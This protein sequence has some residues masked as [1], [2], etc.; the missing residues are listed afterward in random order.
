MTQF[1]KI[2]VALDFSECSWLL[3]D[4][5]MDLAE[6]LDS[7]VVLTHIDELPNG[8]SA[9]T[10]VKTEEGDEVSAE[11]FMNSHSQK[12]MG[13]YKE[14]FD[15]RGL[16]TTT[17]VGRGPVAET[18]LE[19]AKEHDVNLIMMGTHGRRGMSRLLAG[20]VAEK[21]QRFADCPVWTS[22]TVHK[23]TCKARSCNWCDSHVTL[24]RRRLRGEADG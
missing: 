10:P 3:A 2:L 7:H 9:E 14:L 6:K 17:V 12:R 13:R 20:S 8:V 19:T 11:A 4:Q 23:K 16:T 5:A 18:L 15:K 1:K 22:R 24:E 21:V